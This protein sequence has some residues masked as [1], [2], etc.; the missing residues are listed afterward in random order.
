MEKKKNQRWD[1]AKIFGKLIG[2]NSR[3]KKVD[4]E[5]YGIKEW[6]SKRFKE[7][8]VQQFAIGRMLMV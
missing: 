7:E 5:A 3:N 8:M 6:K 2:N 1:D 4:G